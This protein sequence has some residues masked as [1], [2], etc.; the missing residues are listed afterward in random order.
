M[1]KNWTKLFWDWASQIKLSWFNKKDHLKQILNLFFRTSVPL[2]RRGCIWHTYICSE[3]KICLLNANGITYERAQG[4]LP[5]C[6]K[7][8]IYS[9]YLW[10]INSQSSWISHPKYPIP[11]MTPFWRLYLIQAISN[12]M[13]FIWFWKKILDKLRNPYLASILHLLASSSQSC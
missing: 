13:W 12:L 5:R 2:Y 1:H 4:I 10:I 8:H 11:S 7:F 9:L 6:T 3:I